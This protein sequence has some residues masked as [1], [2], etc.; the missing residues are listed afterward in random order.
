MRMAARSRHGLLLAP[1]A[2]ADRNQSALVAMDHAVSTLG[3]RVVRMDFP[4]RL[5]GRRAP[6]REPVLLDAVAREADALAR[7]PGLARSRRWLG[8]R[9]MGGRMC[10]LAVAGGLEALGLVL[11]SY[12]LHPPGKPERLRTAHF[13]SL[14][15]PCLFVSGTRDAFGTPEEMEEATAAIPGAVTHVWLSGRDHGLRG[16]DD[17]VA[18]TVAEWITRRMEEAAP[19]PTTPGPRG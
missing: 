19:P 12:P 10:S 8:G 1:G 2:G 14:H 4:Y 6:D 9:S 11:V 3:V 7:L 16:V 15:V 17:E 18:A 5:A 13:P